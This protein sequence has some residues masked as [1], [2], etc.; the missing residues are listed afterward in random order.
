MRLQAR[1]H[2]RNVTV[3][4]HSWRLSV[5]CRQ[6]HLCTCLQ[7]PAARQPSTTS[8]QAFRGLPSKQVTCGVGL[9]VYVFISF[10]P[11]LVGRYCRAATASQQAGRRPLLAV[12]AVFVCFVL[13]K[14]LT[15]CTAQA[16]SVTY[17]W[18]MLQALTCSCIPP[19]KWQRRLLWRTLQRPS[20]P[21]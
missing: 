7:S 3:S 18:H 16:L 10:E 4:A 12:A 8:T 13:L 17:K 15:L 11:A 14:H 20:S 6:S 21:P 1:L 19:E 9:D 5:H 2:L